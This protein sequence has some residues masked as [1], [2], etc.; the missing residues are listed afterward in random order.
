MRGTDASGIAGASNLCRENSIMFRRKT[1]LRKLAATFRH[2]KA[3]DIERGQ[4]LIQSG[5]AHVHIGL[6][7]QE[8]KEISG[9]KVMPFLQ[10]LAYILISYED[11]LTQLHPVH[12][13]S[14]KGPEYHAYRAASPT[15]RLEG[16]TEE[17]QAERTAKAAAAAHRSILD[18]E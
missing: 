9:P 2:Y 12:R 8:P 17:E 11:L 13:S 5:L 7:I 15:L 1:R 4:P 3:T 18:L 16:E 10:H 6:S 14:S